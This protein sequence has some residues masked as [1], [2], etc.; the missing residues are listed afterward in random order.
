[1]VLEL[2]LGCTGRD[3]YSEKSDAKAE[4]TRGWYP[5]TIYVFDCVQEE[6][7]G[8]KKR[9][10]LHRYR[11]EQTRVGSRCKVKGTG[12]KSQR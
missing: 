7:M 4:R 8:V 9:G 11:Y 5:S 2:I 3:R 1:M 10:G 6:N 12:G